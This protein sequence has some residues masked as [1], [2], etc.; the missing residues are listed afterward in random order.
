MRFYIRTVGCPKNEVDSLAI[1]GHLLLRGHKTVSSPDAADVVIVNTCSFIEAARRESVEAIFSTLKEAP[2]SYLVIAGCLAQ[3]YPEE[4]SR[5]LPEANLIVGTNDIEK[6]IPLVEK[7]EKKQTVFLPDEDVSWLV[8]DEKQ[9]AAHPFAY[10]KVA[11][12][13]DNLCSYC[14]IPGIRGRFRSAP[15]E[16]LLEHTRALLQT[17]IK[18]IIIVAQ[19]T[20]LYGVDIYGE[21]S[22]HLLLSDIASLSYDFWI[23]VMYLHPAHITE[24][25]LDV[26][27][28]E[29]KIIPYLDIPIQ[30]ISDRILSA[31]NRKTTSREIYRLIDRIKSRLPDVTL[32]TSLIVGFPGE[33]ERD[34]E[35]L[36][37]L[38]SR[39]CFEHIGIFRYS[40]EEGTAAFLLP[41]RV[42]KQT[43]GFREE[44][45]SL[46]QEEQFTKIARS[47]RGKLF[48]ALPDRKTEGI[49]F[50]RAYFDAPDVDREI[51]L[52]DKPPLGSFITV[53]IKDFADNRYIGERVKEQE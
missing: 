28:N 42:D 12:G 45:L 10:L 15:R 43:I 21:P 22:L 52:L 36:V 5:E 6:I 11:D 29:P 18:E 39:G 30:H 24:R 14:A 50:A 8:R 19:D 37:N 26:I 20:A 44:I 48:F 33:T 35:K 17:G 46:L 41:E 51:E 7:R 25:I 16:K 49:V 3:R 38:V 9:R 23:R 53:R 2:N 27:S 1:E 4:L 13:C 47:R 32:R 34:F 31:M 40:A